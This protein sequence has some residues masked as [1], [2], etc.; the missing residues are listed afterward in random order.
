MSENMRC[1]FEY[2]DE[3]SRRIISDL[4]DISCFEVSRIRG[5]HRAILSRLFSIICESITGKIPEEKHISL[6]CQCVNSDNFAISIPGEYNFVCERGVCTFVKKE[7]EQNSRIIKLEYGKNII[8]GFALTIF[9]GE[10][11]SK[12]SLNVYKK[13]IH[14]RLPSAI[15]NEGLFLRFRKEG[16]CYRYGGMTHRLKKVFNDRNIP[17]FMRDFIPV[18]CDSEGIVFVPGLS[19]CDRIKADETSVYVTFCFGEANEGESAVYT[20]DK[21]T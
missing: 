10:K 11:L 15:I 8:D 18:L 21:L 5:L 1:A 20:A 12:F 19:L 3:S 7:K 2:I 13:S 16:D 9:I 6:F 4:A 17:P 14:V